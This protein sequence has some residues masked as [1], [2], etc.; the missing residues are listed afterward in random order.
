MK[1]KKFTIGLTLLLTSTLLLT[2]CT[3]N[4]TNDPPV[5]DN[6]TQSTADLVELQMIM[7]D[8]IEMAG[9]GHD[10]TG[11]SPYLSST[12]TAVKVGTTMVASNP[13]APNVQTVPKYYTISFTNTPGNDGHVRN[14]VLKYDYVTSTSTVPIIVHSTPGF[15]ANV[16]ATAYTIDNY[17][18]S[19]NSMTIKNLVASG[20]PLTAGLTPTNVN[21]SWSISA[22]LTVASPSWTRNITGDW[23]KTLLNTGNQA[24]PMPL[25]GTQTFTIFQGPSYASV[26]WAKAYVS[27]SGSGTANLQGTTG[28]GSII[29]YTMNN[30]TR[31]FNSSP[32]GYK[33]I[34]YVPSTNLYFCP[35][36]DDPERHPFL[37][38]LM[39]FQEGA[40]PNRQVDFGAGDVADY[41]AKVTISGITYD[42]DC[43]N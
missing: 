20:F 40:N 7:G 30:L 16:T 43:R 41:N 27:Y 28:G 12:L 39:N 9:Q 33:Y 14:G 11:I 15:I 23:T 37:S 29:K 19:I 42:I 6:N 10:A 34:K 17:S 35:N 21:L 5:P 4:K 18:V 32:E 22:N 24:V 8:I 3:K 1:N 36:V 26:I 38:G 25:T 13:V 31:N 2:N